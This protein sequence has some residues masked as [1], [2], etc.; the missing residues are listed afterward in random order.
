MKP[1]INDKINWPTSSFIYSIV[2]II[3]DRVTKVAINGDL[4]KIYTNV[5]GYSGFKILQKYEKI[6]EIW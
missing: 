4:K 2:E 5:D 1:E 6:I 3:N